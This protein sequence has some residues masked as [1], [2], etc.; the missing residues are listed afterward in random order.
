MES[1]ADYERAV[2]SAVERGAG[3][4]AAWDTIHDDAG[5]RRWWMEAAT[6]LWWHARPNGVFGTAEARAPEPPVTLREVGALVALI[7][8]LVAPLVRDDL[9]DP[10][11]VREGVLRTLSPEMEAM[12]IEHVAQAGLRADIHRDAGHVVQV[13]DWGRQLV[14]QFMKRTDTSESLAEQLSCHA[15]LHVVDDIA[16]T[17]TSADYQ[18]QIVAAG[19]SLVDV[20]EIVARS[21]QRGHRFDI[22]QMLHDQMA[23]PLGGRLAARAGAMRLLD[24]IEAQHLELS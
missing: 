3:D 17:G 11:H 7:Q 8:C 19:G 24:R 4:A 16:R 9:P 6:E 20:V 15:E 18:R 12:D 5:A 13:R 10:L 21:F 22:P 2:H 23:T 1:F 14:T